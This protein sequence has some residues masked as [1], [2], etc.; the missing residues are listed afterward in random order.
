[1]PINICVAVEYFWHTA[2]PG[3]T[4]YVAE[5]WEAPSLTADTSGAWAPGTVTCKQHQHTPVLA[6]A[7]GANAVAPLCCSR[8]VGSELAVVGSRHPSRL[9][10]CKAASRLLLP[11]HSAA[12]AQLSV[13][14]MTMSRFIT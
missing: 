13:H 9:P 11:Q 12:V 3:M 10:V 14:L 8:W 4:R 6:G 2:V 1:M 7:C 5:S